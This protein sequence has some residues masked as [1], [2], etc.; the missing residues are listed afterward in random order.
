MKYFLMSLLLVFGASCQSQSTSEKLNPKAFYDKM[1]S[2]P[3]SV[4][5][6]VRSSDEF[7]D[8]AIANAINV[9]YNDD[10]FQSNIKKL[11]I[12]KTY[13]VYC[14]S[15]GRSASAVSYMKDNGFKN[16]YELKGGIMAWKK[17][18]LK[19]TDPRHAIAADKIS[20]EQYDAIA[21]SSELVLI[22]FYAPWCGPCMKMAPLLDQLSKEYEGKAKIVRINIDENKTLTQ[23]LQIDEIPFFKLYKG[24]KVAGNYVGQMGRSDF[25]RILK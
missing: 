15:G 7:N 1:Q 24:G 17:D 20:A 8:G 9:N 13:F 23:Q 6:D 14:L 10:Q 21:N 2:L 22:D 12:N 4:L 25:E 11:D 19:V 3:E 5:I 16:V 18:N